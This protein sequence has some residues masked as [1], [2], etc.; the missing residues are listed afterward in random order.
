MLATLQKFEL[1]WGHCVGSVQ[2]Q[3]VHH[4]HCCLASRF[5]TSFL[6]FAGKIVSY[7]SHQEMK[8]H[9]AVSLIVVQ[10]HFADVRVVCSV[11]CSCVPEQ[12]HLPKSSAWKLQ[13][14]AVTEG[15][16]K[17][18]NTYTWRPFMV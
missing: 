3:P 11:T 16:T 5:A 15:G 7:P 2:L 17:Q 13:L 14:P 18:G 8:K 9:E 10:P 4:C 12:C 1:V 6:H